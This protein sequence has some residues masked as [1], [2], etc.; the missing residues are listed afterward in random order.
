MKYVV[1]ALLLLAQ[2]ASFTWV[3]RARNSGSISYHATAAF[4]SHLTWFAGQ[5]VL[6]DEMFYVLRTSDWPHAL[7]IGVFYVVF[8]LLGSIG[9]HWLSLNYLE[10][11]RRK[12]GA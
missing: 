8:M 2:S 3:S 7:G 10:V 4:F 11:G 9:M 6:V 1:W 5:F 12:V